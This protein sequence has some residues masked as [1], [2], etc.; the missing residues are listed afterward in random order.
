[1]LHGGEQHDCVVHR[2]ADD[3]ADQQPEKARQVAVLGGQYRADQRT[4][5]G[6]GRE[7]LAEVDPLVGRHIV[8][9]IFQ[10]VGGGDQFV[11]SLQ[12]LAHKEHAVEA[13]G[14]GEDAEGRNDKSDCVLHGGVSF[15]CGQ[16]GR[17]QAALYR[18]GRERGAQKRSVAGFCPRAAEMRPRAV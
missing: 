9:A 12:H 1:M 4:G 17:A 15:S 14:N 10:L 11:V 18:C 5:G 16:S 2:A 3:A 13:I 8:L 6:D 7:V